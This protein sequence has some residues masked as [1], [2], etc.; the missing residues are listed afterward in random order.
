MSSPADSLTE[1]ATRRFGELAI[2]LESD[3]A[4]AD[5]L[6]LAFKHPHLDHEIKVWQRGEAFEVAYNDALPPGPAEKDFYWR[7]D[8]EAAQAVDDV[9]SFLADV[10]AGRIVVWRE[11]LGSFAQ[12]SRGGECES[13]PW[14]SEPGKEDPRTRKSCLVAYSWGS[15]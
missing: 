6:I 15:Q 7:T 14:F 3:P 5:R 2:V 10:F 8:K 12:W 11:R 13:L 4:A 1:S 9:V